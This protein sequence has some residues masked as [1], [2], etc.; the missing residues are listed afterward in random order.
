MSDKTTTNNNNNT[1][2]ENAEKP[3]KKPESSFRRRI[4]YGSFA[5]IFTAVTIALIFVLNLISTAYHRTNPMMIDMTREQIF[6]ISDA[7]RE[8]MADIDVPVRIVFFRPIDLFEAELGSIGRMIVN[9]IRDFA[10]EF[11]FVSVESICIIRNPAAVHEFT[12]SDA[13]RPSTNSIAIKAGNTPRLLRPEAFFVQDSQTRRLLGFAG[14]RT[15]AS[16]VLQVTNDDS[17]LALFTVGHGETMPMEFLRLLY[18]EGFR[19]QPID[20]SVEEI[21]EDARL[22]VINNPIRDFIGAD[23]DNPLLRSE[24]DA[25]ATFLNNFGNV[26]YFT[27]PQA[28]PLPELDGLLR[29]WNIEFLHGT[30]V[31]DERGAFDMRGLHLNA[32]LHVSGGVGDELHASIRRLPTAPRAIVPQTKPMAILDLN[33]MVNM[34]PILRSADTARIHSTLEENVSMGPGS[35]DLMVFANRTQ[36]INNEPR[37]SF[38]L[39]SGSAMFLDHLNDNSFSNDD[40]ILN[41]LRIMTRQRV[42]TD[43][44]WRRFDDN[45]LN[46]DLG[47]QGDWTII[48]LIVAPAIPALVGVAVWLK[49][50]YS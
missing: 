44:P 36:F 17:P 5:I 46:M 21:P 13:T 16:T 7:T 19:I 38:L 47:A 10:A 49:R 48:V 26:M 30:Q 20:L 43:V 14:E 27:S 18:N 41:A 15:L 12:T 40:I 37:N 33:P 39:A 8:L 4:K 2:T 6:Q 29:E 1:N 23:P 3:I 9:I 32:Q 50:R 11:D 25:V 24:I 28:G 42:T 34:S 45:R 35:F 22:M 31:Q